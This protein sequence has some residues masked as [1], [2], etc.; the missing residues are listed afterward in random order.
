[1]YIIGVILLF[2][3]PRAAGCACKGILRWKETNQIETYLI[4]FFFL[5]FVQGVVFAP[6]VFAGLPFSLGCTAIMGISTLVS[7][8]G[9]VMA[10]FSVLKHSKIQE[11]QGEKKKLPWRKGDKLLFAG[12][13]MVFALLIV[14]MVLGMDILR[15][16]IVLETVN[17]T[18]S[19]GTMFEYHPLTGMKMDGGMITSKKIVT[20]PLFYAAIAVLTGIETETL[21][22]IVVNLLVLICSYYVC[23]LLFT[24]ITVYTR[25]KLYVVWLVYGLLLLAGDYHK[26]TL[27]YRILYQGYEGTT[28]CFAVILPYLLYVILSWYRQECDEEKTTWGMRI[29]YLLKLALGGVTSMVITGL[30]TG[31]LF[32]GASAGIAA[33]CCLL[34]SIREVAACKE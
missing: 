18:V 11:Q 26:S 29:M 34:K 17:T 4:G 28:I 9:I 16:D 25:G 19:T 31:L 24:K 1:M 13:L 2:I 6:C 22:Y 21:L 33:V 10:L 30:G 5:F 15:D 32:L 27:M 3:L 23:A 20:L 12:M 8:L 7:V 14:R